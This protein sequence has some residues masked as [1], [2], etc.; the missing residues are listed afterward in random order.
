MSNQSKPPQSVDILNTTKRIFRVILGRGVSAAV[1][2]IEPQGIPGDSPRLVRIIGLNRGLVPS[3][4]EA[5]FLGAQTLDD[6]ESDYAISRENF[7]R[8]IEGMRFVLQP[9]GGGKPF[10][11]SNMVTRIE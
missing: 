11:C 1:C 4:E 7:D 6:F 10:I 9:V 2:I 8:L 3:P 5:Y